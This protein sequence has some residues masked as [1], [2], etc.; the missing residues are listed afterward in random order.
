M[1]ANGMRECIPGGPHCL[2]TSVL[3]RDFSFGEEKRG[4]AFWILSLGVH[5]ATGGIHSILV[6]RLTSLGLLER[7]L[8]RPVLG[9]QFDKPL[10]SSSSRDLMQS[11]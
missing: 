1:Y 4:F 11:G 2:D 5:D 7:A 3:L 6:S 8:V 9:R 10:V